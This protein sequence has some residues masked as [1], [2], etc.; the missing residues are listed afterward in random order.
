MSSSQCKV[1]ECFLCGSN[2]A[3]FCST[4]KHDLCLSC[5]ETHEQDIE[6]ID[7]GILLYH[8]PKLE[9][10][11]RHPNREYEKYCTYCKIPICSKCKGNEK[12]TVVLDI[13][14][15]CQLIRAQHKEKIDI[16]SSETILSRTILLERAKADVKI[17]REKCLLFQ[18]KMFIKAQSLKDIIDKAAEK[19]FM[20]NLFCGFFKH[21]CLKQQK[22][23]GK[24][25]V[26]QQTYVY[27]YEYSS[28]Y[29]IQ[30][31]SIKKTIDLTE[32][33]LTLHD[34]FESLSEKIIE[35]GYRHVGTEFMLKCLPK[36][37]FHHTF[38]VN[39][40]FNCNHISCVN[41]DRI[42]VSGM[43]G[44]LNLSKRSGE[45]LLHLN[46]HFMPLLSGYHT[47]NRDGDLIYIDNHYKL[48]K[49][50]KENNIIPICRTD[51]LSQE[52]ASECV[53][54][55]P[56]T[57]DILVGMSISTVFPPPKMTDLY[58]FEKKKGRIFRFNRKGLLTQTTYAN[59]KELYLSSIPKFITEN[60]NGDVVI[61]A[62][63][64]TSHEDTSG[65]VEVINRH[66]K[67][68]FI[69]KGHQQASELQ[70]RGICTDAL[71]HILVCD[72]KTHSVQMLDKDG[73]F[74][75]YLLIRPPGIFTP[76]SLF[77]D[78]KTHHLWVG[79]IAR[80]TVCVYRYL[81]R[82]GNLAGT[83]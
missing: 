49:I 33:H 8:F 59:E 78:S 28:S 20:N 27:R 47:V 42:W 4:C 43:I 25:I 83:I 65:V 31:I 32:K 71:S 35:R 66:G 58:R 77:Y 30:F 52:W 56:I 81:S 5:K 21:R 26:N 7:H 39:D 15:V 41:L 6:T 3:Y 45:N 74:L 62:L 38:T 23:L 11:A 2:T 9:I 76:S 79:S 22:E 19:D 14:R 46:L 16:I 55:S 53:Y 10:C 70:P 51:E 1:R 63:N 24:C 29:P 57:E 44:G 12:H 64:M 54:S 50:S 72:L 37:E 68:R 75:S 61:S 36:V 18:N 17:A 69:Y 73:K 60:N 82:P 13:N 80:N 40:V 67:S 34:V 48:S